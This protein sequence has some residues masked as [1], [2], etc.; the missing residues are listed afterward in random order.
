[1]VNRKQH[2]VTWHIDDVKSSHVDSKVNEHSNMEVK[3]PDMLQQF[4]ENDMII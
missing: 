4:A 1:M 3:K 2:T